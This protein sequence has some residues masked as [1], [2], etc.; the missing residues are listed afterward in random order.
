M[1]AQSTPAVYAARCGCWM[2]PDLRPIAKRLANLWPQGYN[3]GT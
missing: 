1:N 3:E 2:K